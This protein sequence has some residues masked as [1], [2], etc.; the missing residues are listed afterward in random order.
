MGASI[1]RG[2]LVIGMF[3]SWVL[4]TLY[5]EHV[6]GY[7]AWDTGLAFLPMTLTVGALSLGTTARVMGRLGPERTVLAG[8]S[9]VVVALL[10][11]SGVSDR[12]SYFP[13]LFVPFALMGLGMGTAMLPLLTIAMSGVAEQDAGLASGIVNVSMQLAGALGIAVLGTLAADRSQ[14]LSAA[15]AN[16]AHALTG[17]YQLAFE[18]AGGAVVVGILIALAVLRMPRER[19]PAPGSEVAV[20]V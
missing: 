10:L 6:L 4:G 18:V 15:G 5:V 20:E 9:I 11:L 17:G 16:V 19:Q 7:G 13:D 1:V 14:E 3:S 12:A 8:L 2:F